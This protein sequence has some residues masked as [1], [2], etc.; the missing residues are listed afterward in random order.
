M[1]IN[2]LA[3]FFLYI[4]IFVLFVVQT[5]CT[6][7]YSAVGVDIP[8]EAKTIS[9]RQFQNNAPLV[10]LKLSN[11][12]T[13]KLKDKFQSSTRLFLVENRGDLSIVGEITGY[14]V[15]TVSV[16]TDKA[17]MNRL[18]ITVSI[19]YENSFDE[20]KNATRSFSR[21]LDFAST[22]SLAQVEDALTSDI[23]D[24]LVDDIFQA[25]V[26]NW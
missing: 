23:C 20:E 5:S 16:G 11:E 21:Y 2:R 1:S 19:T 25:T 18:T 14:S 22:M 24:V 3:T 10:N 4:N 15:S 9:I 6:V 26:G 8:A 13:T 12:I 17:T 7:K